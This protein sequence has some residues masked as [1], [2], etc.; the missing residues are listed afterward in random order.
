MTQPICHLCPQ[1][2]PH[3]LSCYWTQVPVVSSWHLT[4]WDMPHLAPRMTVSHLNTIFKTTTFSPVCTS[5][6]SENACYQLHDSTIYVPYMYFYIQDVPKIP[7]VECKSQ[8]VVTGIMQLIQMN[9]DSCSFS[10]QCFHCTSICRW[11]VC[12]YIQVM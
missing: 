1:H 8:K 5:P 12:F 2:A 6:V 4:A 3:G 7:T 9:C 10:F 11:L